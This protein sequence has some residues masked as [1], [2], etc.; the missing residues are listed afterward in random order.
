MNNADELL[1]KN[2]Q[3]EEE[4]AELR[5]QLQDDRLDKQRIQVELS[6]LLNAAYSILETH[7]FEVTARKI[8]EACSRSIGAKAGYVALMS[9]NGQ[10]NELL[11]LEDGG[12]SCTV[13]PD[14]PMPIRG[15]RAECYKLG[16]VIYDNDFMNS[17]W[18][19]FMPQGH[20]IL[21][22]VLF[23]PLNIKGKTMGIMGFSNK[24][25]DFTEHDAKLA[26]AFGEYAAIALLNSKNIDA[27]EK[28]TS[29][30]QE[31]N[32]TKDKLFSIISH[33]LKSPFTSILGYANLIHEHVHENNF[34]KIEE[35]SN[36][37]MQASM[38]TYE[39]VENLLNWSRLQK[40]AITYNPQWFILHE[41]VKNI[42]MLLQDNINAKNI[43][44]SVDINP[45]LKLFADQQMMEIVIRNLVS[46]A[47]KFT[48][49]NGTV[50]IKV[51]KFSDRMEFSVYDSGI[52]IEK[53]KIDKLFDLES[54]F[55]TPG[56]NKEKG[57]GLGLI[58][59]K[60]FITKHNG[61][62]EARSELGKGSIFTFSIPL[63]PQMDNELN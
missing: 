34:D 48:T 32:A 3:L 63:P 10:E 14:L 54:S 40:D 50:E 38:N 20:V 42:I 46:N 36:L 26:G 5:K 1:K 23:A 6:E 44:L 33:D 30:L 27:L 4:A 18:V 9:E 7:N 59:C 21:K 25:D 53:E 45:K 51:S 8:F 19:K 13:N 15:L 58:L 24:D 60:E 55:S 16:K 49:E 35:Y 12:L 17:K 41:T 37:M 39:L 31:L 11:F 62:I 47:V 43:N 29:K 57:T 22:N 52:G 28:H 2:Q 56:T 61:T